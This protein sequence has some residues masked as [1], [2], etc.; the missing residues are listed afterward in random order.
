M[1]FPVFFRFFF[2][3]PIPTRN[4]GNLRRG[5]S[6]IDEFCAKPTLS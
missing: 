6:R 4:I 3:D 1:V 5:S 2:Y